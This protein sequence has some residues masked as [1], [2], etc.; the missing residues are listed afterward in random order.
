MEELLGMLTDTDDVELEPSLQ[1]LLLDLVGDAIKSNVA[2]WEDR[3]LRLR[4]HCGSC[5]VAVV[6]D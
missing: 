2:L 4:A 5:H 3:L 6:V 1:Q